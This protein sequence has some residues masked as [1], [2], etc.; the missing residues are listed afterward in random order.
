MPRGRPTGDHSIAQLRTMIKDRQDRKKKLMNER[1][2]VQK[3]MDKLDRQIAVLDGQD[4]GEAGVGLTA[5]GRPRNEQPLPDVIE[6][7][8]KKNKGPM[9]VGDIAE[10][11][12]GTGYHS[13][14]ANFKGIV[15]QALIKDDRFSS[16]SRGH[17]QLK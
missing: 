8:L 4:N 6:S 17:Y 16:A 3:Q 2:K 1:K 14:S 13:S 5:G 7:V 15:N 10:A 12:E 11:V 9:R